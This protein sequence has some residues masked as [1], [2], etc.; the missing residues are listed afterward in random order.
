MRN[1]LLKALP[2]VIT[3]RLD[4]DDE[5]FISV[6][7]AGS[8]EYAVGV[9]AVL[10]SGAAVVPISVLLSPSEAVYYAST[11][12][13]VAVLHSDA[14]ESQAIELSR[15]MKQTGVRSF[16]R[17]PIK[18]ST[19][20]TLLDPSTVLISSDRCLDPNKAGVVIFTSGTTGPPKGAVMRRTHYFDE[21]QGVADHYQITRFDVLLHLLPVHHATGVGMMFFP[22]L[23]SGAAI[24][25]RSGGFD[26][27]WTWERFRKRG[28][29]FFSAVPTIYMRMKRHFEDKLIAADG[30]IEYVNGARSLK[31]CMCGT[32]ALPKPIADFW[33]DILGKKIMLRY[34]GTEFGATLRHRIGDDFIPDVV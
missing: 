12:N 9:L 19:C 3:R 25:F 2:A 33:T 28:L 26:P 7:A 8:Y 11:S 16:Q 5:I 23:I 22:F 4:E 10:A 32:S 34:G 24:E 17:I 1:R 14:A 15:P 6:L 20:T 27:A 18:P 21:A 31:V 30:A 13:S 29:T